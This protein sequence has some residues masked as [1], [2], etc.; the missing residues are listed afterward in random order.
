MK[1]KIPSDTWISPK[2]EIMQVPFKGRGMFARERIKAGE[3]VMVWGGTWGVDYMDREAAEKAEEE[4]KLIMQW[5]D[6]LYSAETPGDSDGYFINHSCD[7]N[8]WMTDA[9][10]HAARRDIERGEEVTNDYA[11]M[12]A[13]EN[14]ISSWKCK[15]GSPMCR[16]RVTGKDWRLPELQ[17]RYQGHFSPLINKRIG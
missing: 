9:F 17:K 2:I 10:T 3:K 16:G 6:D 15:C 4:G 11:M 7:P 8:T 12:E 1:H 5:D 14:Y 13:D